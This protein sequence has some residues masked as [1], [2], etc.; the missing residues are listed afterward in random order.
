MPGAG[1]IVAAVGFL[2]TAIGI[3]STVSLQA[4]AANHG[5]R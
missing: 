5:H 3:L 2:G 4:N 1:D